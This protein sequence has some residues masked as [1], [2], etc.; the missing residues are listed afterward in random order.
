MFGF[1]KATE[2][3]ERLV[4]ARTRYASSVQVLADLQEKKRDLKQELGEL[5]VKHG[6]LTEKLTRLPGQR[7]DLQAELSRLSEER[8]L[9]ERELSILEK[10]IDGTR[11]ELERTRSAVWEEV[12]AVL[13]EQAPPGIGEWLSKTCTAAQ[14]VKRCDGLCTVLDRIGWTMPE[15]RTRE[16]IGGQE[17]SYYA[18]ELRKEFSLP[19]E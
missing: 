18:Q 5:S 8:E 9:V 17:F 14:L 15:N 1:K 12:L 16:S 11:V 10:R 4:Q 2:L 6:E 3:P 19:H 13:V 7:Q